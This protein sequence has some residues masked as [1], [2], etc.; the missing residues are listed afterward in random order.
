MRHNELRGPTAQLLS[1]TCPNVSTEPEL[2]PLSGESLTY[3][4]SNVQDGA[5]LDV[6]AEGFWGDR[7]QSAF[8][9]VRVFNPFALS[10]CHRT[11]VSATDSMKGKS[12]E[13]MIEESEK[14][15]TAPS[16]PWIFLAAGGMGTV[17]TVTYKRLASLLATKHLQ[18]Y[19]RTMGWLRCRISFSLLRSVITCLRGA[20]FTPGHPVG[21]TQISDTNLDLVISKAMVPTY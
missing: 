2:Q 12:T 3:L 8:F 7:H 4:I 1:E 11:L 5:C 6:R 21:W 17:A 20:R 13:N 14:L 16:L 19:S 10:N 9:D 15:N 18:P